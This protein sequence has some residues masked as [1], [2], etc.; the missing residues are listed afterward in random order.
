MGTAFQI[1]FKGKAREMRYTDGALAS[2]YVEV[3]TL[4]RRHVVDIADARRSRRFGPYAN[5]DLFPG[6]IRRAAVAAGVKEVSDGKYRVDL[7][8]PAPDGMTIDTT[9]FLVEVTIDVPDVA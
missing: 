3:P 8:K 5:S 9:G 1:R 6:M 7:T 2:R 4:E